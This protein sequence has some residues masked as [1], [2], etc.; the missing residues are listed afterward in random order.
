MTC[1]PH[2]YPSQLSGKTPALL[3][4]SPSSVNDAG[5]LRTIDRH[6]RIA[7]KVER[8]VDEWLYWLEAMQQRIG[9]RL[10]A[11]PQWSMRI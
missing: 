3:F 11:E 8:V 2:H 9:W 4:T 1:L 7:D 5:A 10:A 6:R